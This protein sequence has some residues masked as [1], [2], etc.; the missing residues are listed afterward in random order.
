MTAPATLSPVHPLPVPAAL[1]SRRARLERF[2]PVVVMSLVLLVAMLT[3]T[4]WP[5]GA[6][7]DD[8]MYTVLAKALA[9][10]EGYRLISLPGAPHGTHYPPGYPLLLSLLWRIH[11]SFPD[12]IVLFKFANAVLL[13]LAALGAY[14]FGRRLRLEALPAAGLALAGTLSIVVLLVTGVVMSEPLFM[15]LLLPSLLLAERTAESGSARSA[16]AVGALLGLLALV[17]TLGAVAIPAAGLV[18]LVRRRPRAAAA[19]VLAG[20]LVLVPWQLWVSAYQHEVP[21]ALAGKYGAYGSWLAD[22]YRDGGWPFAWGVMVTNILRLHRLLGY[23]F[24]PVPAQWPHTVAFIVTCVLLI[25]G[26]VAMARRAPVTATFLALYGAVVLLWPFEPDRFLLGIWPLLLFSLYS[27][28]V[29]IWRWAPRPVVARGCRAAALGLALAIVAGNLAY[30]VRGY[31]G[32]WWA[33][34]QREAGRSAKPILEWVVRHT[35]MDDVL[36]TEHD[37]IVYLYTGRRALPV[38]T[39]LARER[40]RPLTPA[41]TLTWVSSLLT[42]YRPRYYITRWSVALRAA[43]TLVAQQPPLLRRAG[44]TGNALVYEYVGR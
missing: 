37:L 13:A 23:L 7:E 36:S 18:L 9:T 10:G 39:F 28:I 27:A 26:V 14:R 12:N 31:R 35:G 3:I 40:V 43:D 34:V 8:A 29:A 19:L 16:A 4:P 41:E 33:S 17:R 5:V 30:N 2:A 15:A 21:P 25:G 38:S 24:M 44:N 11:P 32:Q 1:S 22:G 42:E 6:F 20:F